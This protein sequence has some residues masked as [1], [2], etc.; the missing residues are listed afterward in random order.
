MTSLKVTTKSG[1][2]KATNKLS[3]SETINSDD[4][5]LFDSKL[6]RGFLR[7]SVDGTA[8]ITYLGPQGISLAQFL[9]Q[10]IDKTVFFLIMAQIVETIKR[11]EH[12]GF[13]LRN[14]VLN[15]RQV[16]INQTSKELYFIYQ[17]VDSEKTS[18]D[19]VAFI[20]EIVSCTLFDSKEDSKDVLAFMAFLYQTEDV[21]PDEIESF[22]GRVCP[23]VYTQLPKQDTGNIKSSKL[24]AAGFEPEPKSNTG[25]DAWYKQET[26]LLK[27]NRANVLNEP[28]PEPEPAAPPAPVLPVLK[29]Q[30]TGEEVVIDK[31]SFRIGKEKNFV[32]YL[33]SD[34]NAISRSH[35]DITTRDGRVFITDLGSTNKT[36]INEAA[37]PAQ[38]ET[39]IFGGDQLKLANEIFELTV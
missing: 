12:Y 29:R 6:L 33:I 10:P 8:K 34:N 20:E 16:F 19:V 38:K 21:A 15:K 14:L 23:S 11:T 18:A 37:I 36:Y 13:R 27:E 25:D 22:I 1:Q 30:K 32:D 2:M 7:P 17:P 31:P 39:E 26:T 24:S 28:E 35:A 3:G 4:M 9:R 5:A